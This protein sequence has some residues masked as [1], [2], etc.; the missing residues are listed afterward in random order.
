MTKIQISDYETLLKV[1][2][3]LHD[4]EFDLE[5][6][7]YDEKKKVW[8]G[9]FFKPNYDDKKNIRT[10]RKYLI[11]K[12]YIYPT[13]E[14][15][16]RLN[17]ISKA[18]IQD[19]AQIVLFTFNKIMKTDNGYRLLFNENMDIDLLCAGEPSGEVVNKEVPDKHTYITTFLFMD[20][21][22]KTK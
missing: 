8:E 17:N 18:I 16:L 15:I 9:K 10:E 1:C 21:G 3:E 5:S 13:Y 19:K 7:I 6:V 22:N 11:F 14:T 2:D 12:K 4:C 20:F